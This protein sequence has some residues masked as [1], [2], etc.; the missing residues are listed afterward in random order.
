MDPALTPAH[1]QAYGQ[2]LADEAQAQVDAKYKPVVEAAGFEVATGVNVVDGH[3]SA[4]GIAESI[5]A[6][7]NDAGADILAVTS[8]GGCGAAI[9]CSASAPELCTHHC[10]ALHRMHNRRP[11]R[12]TWE[13]GVICA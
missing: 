2:R 1:L 13:P 5:V 4:A 9:Q 10:A 12:R 8:H 7:A 3:A 11:A 6:S